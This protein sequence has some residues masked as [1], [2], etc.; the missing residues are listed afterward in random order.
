[1]TYAKEIANAN[2]PE[3]RQFWIPTQTSLA[4]PLNDLQLGSWKSAVGEDVRPFSAVAYFFAKRIFQ[5]YHIP[6]GI[7]NASVGGSPIEAWTSED[8]LK[9]FSGLSAVLERN[10]DT[11]YINGVRRTTTSAVPESL[12][13]V[14]DKGMTKVQN[15]L[16]LIMLP[17][18]GIPFISPILGRPGN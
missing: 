14:K 11:A 17:K 16:R 15:G 4:G 8:G 2:D 10:K 6:I 1:V 12:P 18:R 9:E 7:I 13:Q 5:K 3:I